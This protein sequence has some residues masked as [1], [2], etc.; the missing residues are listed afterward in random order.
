MGFRLPEESFAL[1]RGRSVLFFVPDFFAVVSLEPLKFGRRLFFLI[2]SLLVLAPFKALAKRLAKRPLVYLTW[3]RD[4]TTT[5]MVNWLDADSHSP[6]YVLY[7]RLAAPRGSRW[8]LAR[9]SRGGGASPAFLACTL[10]SRGPSRGQERTCR[11]TR[12]GSAKSLSQGRRG[13]DWYTWGP[14]LTFQAGHH[15]KGNV[16]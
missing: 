13:G 15:K 11:L 7:R 16:E 4:P 1:T 6:D 2:L 14:V 12:G 9:G 8:T 10:K 5:M 3:M